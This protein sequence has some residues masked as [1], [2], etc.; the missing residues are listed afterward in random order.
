[1]RAWA[2][3][4]FVGVA[5][6]LSASAQDLTNLS[7]KQTEALTEWGGAVAAYAH[8]LGAC[9]HHYNRASAD[10]ALAQLAGDSAGSGNRLDGLLRQIWSQS[11]SEGRS[12]AS[13]HAW[14]FDRCETLF[15]D[16]RADIRATQRT[17]RTQ[18][19]GLLA[20]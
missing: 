7:P 18:I 4:A 8:Y 15:K 5:V 16:A 19:P 11:Y 17:L 3:A 2:C 9:E 20:P 10:R 1:M 13:E 14:S 12:A 6:A